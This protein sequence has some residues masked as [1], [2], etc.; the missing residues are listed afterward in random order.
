MVRIQAKKKGTKQEKRKRAPPAIDDAAIDSADGNAEAYGIDPDDS[1][2]DGT[3]NNESSRSSS[4]SLSES[5]SSDL[6]SEEE[7]DLD[8]DEV[9]RTSDLP[10]CIILPIYPSF[11]RCLKKIIRYGEVSKFSSE[12]PAPTGSCDD[13]CE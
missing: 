3:Y 10:T 13:C 2:R 8:S 7:R 4:V 11:E 5:V 1:E 9:R 12:T 6:S